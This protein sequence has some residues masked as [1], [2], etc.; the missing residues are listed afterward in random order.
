M[1]QQFS[2]MR[3]MFS[4]RLDYLDFFG[5]G[6]YEPGGSVNAQGRDTARVAAAAAVVDEQRDL[7]IFAYELRLIGP[8]GHRFPEL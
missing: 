2:Q 6:R 5:I 4:E 7:R 1:S 3:P 8:R